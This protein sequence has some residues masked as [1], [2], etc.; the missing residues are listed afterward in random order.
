M[1][2]WEEYLNNPYGRRVG[3]CSV[4]AVAKAIGSDWDRAYAELALGGFVLKDMPS[5]NAV[6]GSVLKQYGFKRDVIP[7]TCPDCYTVADFA[8][9]H[10]EG[11]YV[12]GTSSH[13]VCVEDGTIYDSWDSSDEIAIFYWAE[14]PEMTEEAKDDGGV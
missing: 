8:R 9:E 14:D 4:R 12:V 1:S 6:I 2:G 5:G 13:V 11:T 3:D 10:P 7:N